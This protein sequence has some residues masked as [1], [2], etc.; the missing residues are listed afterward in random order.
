M[1]LATVPLLLM[2]LLAWYAFYGGI[3]FGDIDWYAT[4]LRGLLSSGPLYD[5]TKLVPHPLERPVFWDQAPSTALITPLL[6]PGNGWLW[7]LTMFAATIGGMALVW[8]RV[9]AGGA[10]LLAPV[11][12]LWYPIT[13]ALFWANVNGLVF[14]LLALAW[15]FP[16]AAG[17][18]IGFAA[19]IKLLPILAVSWLLG[20]RDWRAAAWALGIPVLA[21]GVVL[22]WKGPQ[23]LADFVV[24]RLNQWTPDAPLHWNVADVLGVPNG[25]TYLAALAVTVVAWRWASLS[26]AIIAMLI[27]LPAMHL[28]Y[29]TWLLVP[30]FGIWMPWLLGHGAG[31]TQSTGAARPGA[32]P[33]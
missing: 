15:R 19:A 27:A 10:V 21:T 12:L 4:G 25:A 32:A 9:G 13:T 22:V 23:T 28:H 7:G 2:G 31:T 29:W 18:A 30:F 24:L 16:K 1:A 26:L 5:A 3:L 17:I 8:P 20:K 11:L 14:F 33:A 6:I